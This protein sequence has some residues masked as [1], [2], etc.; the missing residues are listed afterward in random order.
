MTSVKKKL[1]IIAS[2]LFISNICIAQQSDTSTPKI[3]MNPSFQSE[4]APILWWVHLAL[5]A[6]SLGDDTPAAYGG[7]FSVQYLHNVLSCRILSCAGADATNT[8]HR[9]LIDA[10]LLYGYGWYSTLW[11]LNGSV[12]LSFISLRD[13]IEVGQTRDTPSRKIFGATTN[14][15]IGA[16]WQVN[17]FSKF[18]STSNFG[19][20]IMIGGD[21]NKF[22][23]FMAILLTIEVG[24]F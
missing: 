5:G 11:F 16:S 14:Q 1:A 2:I 22:R 20:G 15:T 18:T 9:S 19:L 10:G 23:S 17:I 7:G 8:P 13:S 3:S 24:M 21:I 12:G 4:S 6:G